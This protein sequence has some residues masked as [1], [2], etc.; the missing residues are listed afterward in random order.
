[1]ISTSIFRL[2]HLEILKYNDDTKKEKTKIKN[3]RQ[4]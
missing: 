3:H 4:N 1:M 2:L